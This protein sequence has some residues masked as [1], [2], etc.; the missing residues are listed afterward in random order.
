MEKKLVINADDFG[1]SEPI[2]RGILAGFEA[3]SITAASA[4]VNLPFTR[5]ALQWAKGQGYDLGWHFNLTLGRPLSPP[6]KLTTLVDRNGSFL[7]LNQ[8]IQKTVLHRIRPQEIDLELQ[9]QW[10]FFCSYGGKPTHLDGHQHVH[11]LPVICERVRDCIK[12]F[13]IPFLRIP[14]EKIA[15]WR[16]LP[17]RTFLFLQKG[18]RPRFWSGIPVRSLPFFGFSLQG[19]GGL[20]SW[21]SLLKKNRWH[22][23]EVMVHA[24]YSSRREE[25]SGDDFPGDRQKELQLLLDPSWKRLLAQSG[26]RPVSFRELLT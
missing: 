25:L 7:P 3:G 16:R 2:T 4:L 24:G 18:A 11:V 19:E 26:F 9:A 22:E 10:D 20:A 8:L 5:Q 12:R 17:A 23:A 21:E 1:L 15:P 14:I 13:Q 6:E